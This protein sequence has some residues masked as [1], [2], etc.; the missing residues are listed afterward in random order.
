MVTSGV[1]FF[2]LSLFYNKGPKVF[3]DK[4]TGTPKRVGHEN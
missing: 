2:V 3:I 1:Y 4:H